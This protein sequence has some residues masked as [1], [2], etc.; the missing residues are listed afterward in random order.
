MLEKIK[1]IVKER[2]NILRIPDR[3]LSAYWRILNEIRKENNE[4]PSRDLG[5]GHKEGDV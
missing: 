1:K 3:M 4:N 2:Y 5:E